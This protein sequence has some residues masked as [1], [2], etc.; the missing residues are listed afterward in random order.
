MRVNDNLTKQP[1]TAIP[2]G[3]S[4]ILMMTVYCDMYL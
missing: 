2:D 3:D 1:Y 4:C